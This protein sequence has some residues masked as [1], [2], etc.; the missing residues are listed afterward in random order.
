MPSKLTILNFF[1]LQDR[2]AP[3]SRPLR[4]GGIFRCYRRDDACCLFGDRPGTVAAMRA[5]AME[6]RAQVLFDFPSSAL[7]R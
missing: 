1:M 7:Q 2:G 6:W 5:A 3:V 4:V